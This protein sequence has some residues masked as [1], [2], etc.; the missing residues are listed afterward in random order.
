MP[1]EKQVWDVMDAKYETITPETPLIEACA[2]LGLSGKEKPGIP[3]LVVMRASGEYL[4]ILTVKD[5]ISYLITIYKQSKKEGQEEDWLTQ[6]RNQGLDDSL[7]T[8][9]DALVHLDVLVRPNQKL[10]EVIQILEDLDLDFMPVSDTEKIIGVVRSTDILAEIA[11][12]PHPR[13]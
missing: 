8:V 10:I 13:G 9:N 4:G 6:V 3:G 1:L 2:I 11:P 5:V 12:K 7:I